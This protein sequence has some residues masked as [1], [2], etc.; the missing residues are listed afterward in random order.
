[1]KRGEDRMDASSAR[2][3]TITS[4]ENQYLPGFELWYDSIEVCYG[5]VK[6]YWYTLK[7]K[8]WIYATWKCECCMYFRSRKS[9][10]SL[11]DVSITWIVI[12]FFIDMGRWWDMEERVRLV[13]VWYPIQFMTKNSVINTCNFEVRFHFKLKVKHK[14]T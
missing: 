5:C 3:K 2:T 8:A 12:I 6:N 10:M 13:I 1:M 9:N 4:L 7:I 11:V 14:N